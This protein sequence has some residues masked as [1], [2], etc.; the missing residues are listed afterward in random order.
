[1]LSDGRILVVGGYRNGWLGTAELY[2]P[3]SGSSTPAN[4]PACHGTLH[5][6]T[7]LRDE[8]VLV[9]GG[10]CGSG[11]SGIVADASIFDPR[12]SSWQVTA[13][14]L[15]A[16]NGMTATLLPDGRVWVI[17]GGDG[18]QLSGT[19]I[20]D[21]ETET[22]STSS[23]LN[24]ARVR[25]SATMLQSGRLLVAGGRLGSVTLNSAELNQ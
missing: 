14:M 16:R 5:E 24:T 12:S 15:Q 2:D 7:V 6:A 1:L 10:A 19:E 13:P 20:Y 18:G 11:S 3:V 9:V 25:H 17:A 22:W 21:P 4:P 23:P 8:R